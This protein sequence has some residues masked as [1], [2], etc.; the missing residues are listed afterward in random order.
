MV[1]N[2]VKFLVI[3]TLG[4][5]LIACSSKAPQQLASFTAQTFDTS[6]YQAKVDNF[7][8]IMDASSS[9][10]EIDNGLEKFDIAKA[11]IDRMN[12]TI[13]SVGL[14]AALRTFGHNPAVSKDL[15]HLFYEPAK[16]SSKKMEEA[17]AKITLPGGT[18]PMG[19]ALFAGIED[20]KALPG[21]SAVFLISDAEKIG[22]DATVAAKKMKETLGA[23]VCIYTILVGN[24][25]DGKILMDKIAQIGGCGSSLNADQILTG[26]GMANFIENSLLAPIPPIVEEVRE[27]IEVVNTDIDGDGVLNNVDRC[28]NTPRGA[29]VDIY[30]CWSIGNILFDFN[31]SVIKPTAYPE[32]NSVAM[33]LAENPEMNIILQGFTDSIGTAKYNM[34]LS[35]QR[36]KAVMNYLIH[37]DINGN[38]ILCE[39]FGFNNPIAPNDTD[40]G[41]AL[42]RRVQIRPVM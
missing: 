37:K 23:N 20:I 35:L 15:T 1:R 16:Y 41:R 18:S 42:N 17:L 5:S 40:E 12:Q 6:A 22:A 29:I 32:L 14:N 10:G 36:A 7:L 28:P 19:V 31:K 13:P 27:I 39:G 30:G 24:N 21:K 25:P 9:E 38:R 11:V 34:G 26:A 2:C 33:I 3:L 4:V 8:I